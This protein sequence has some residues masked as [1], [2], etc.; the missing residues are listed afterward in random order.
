MC[1]A[2]ELEI[3]EKL[4]VFEELSIQKAWGTIMAIKP[5]ENSPVAY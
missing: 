2:G 5:S 1:S 4:G 3:D